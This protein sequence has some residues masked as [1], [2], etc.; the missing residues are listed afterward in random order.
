MS[1][2]PEYEGFDCLHSV[3][4]KPGSKMR[5]DLLLGV[6]AVRNSVYYPALVKLD[7]T[8]SLG[9]TITYLCKAGNDAESKERFEV[10]QSS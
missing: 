8:R 7:R 4:I 10:S 6:T 2:P 3:A 1:L 5:T 9:M